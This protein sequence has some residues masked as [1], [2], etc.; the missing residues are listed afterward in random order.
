VVAVAA[1]GDAAHVGMLERGAAFALEGQARNHFRVIVEAR[2]IHLLELLGAE[3]LDAHRDVLH[4]FRALLR[5]DHH[6]REAH[7]LGLVISRARG[8]NTSQ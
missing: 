4:V 8:W 5:G 2:D 3:R 6:F 1:A 7:G